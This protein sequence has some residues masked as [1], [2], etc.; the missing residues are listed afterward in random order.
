LLRKLAKARQ[1][2]RRRV[3]RGWIT[4]SMKPRSAATKGLAK[5]SS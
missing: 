4:S 1:A 3:E 5:R 2:T